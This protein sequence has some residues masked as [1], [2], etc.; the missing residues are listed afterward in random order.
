MGLLCLNLYDL[1]NTFMES[2]KIYTP[3]GK[4][5]IAFLA[6]L[7]AAVYLKVGKV[8]LHISPPN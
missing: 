6:A 4:D 3:L 2:L 8:E 5:C 1:E 7:L